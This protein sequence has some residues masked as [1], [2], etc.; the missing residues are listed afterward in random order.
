MN[1]IFHITLLFAVML[2]TCP[3]DML[4]G[5]ANASMPAAQSEMADC[6]DEMVQ[7]SVDECCELEAKLDG[8]KVK[9][10]DKFTQQ[11]AEIIIPRPLR[12]RPQQPRA[13]DA[14]G[15]PPTLNPYDL[16]DRLLT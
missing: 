1:R 11:T 3:C 16:G 7:K 14:D 5:G 13:P 2:F 15:L 9:A 8:S 12:T 6:H 4:M 10:A